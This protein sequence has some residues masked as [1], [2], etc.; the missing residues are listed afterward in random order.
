M[1]NIKYKSDSFRGAASITPSDSADLTDPISAIYVGGT[2]AIK[3]DMV[4]G[5]TVVFAAVSVGVF[6][7]AVTRVYST[8]TAAT[9]MIGLK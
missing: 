2:G 9:N 1:S 7:I 5:E 6:P 3:V 4:S 8:G